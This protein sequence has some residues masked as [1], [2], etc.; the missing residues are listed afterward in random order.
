PMLRSYLLPNV[1]HEFMLTY[2]LF[3]DRRG[4]IW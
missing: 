1:T 3:G 2:A 4:M